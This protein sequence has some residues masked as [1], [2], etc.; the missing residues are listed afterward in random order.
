MMRI[1]V[2]EWLKKYCSRK[3]HVPCSRQNGYSIFE[4]ALII[5]SICVLC[6][7]RTWGA[8]GDLPIIKSIEVRNIGSGH[9]D[10]SFVLTHLSA[11]KGSALDRFAVSRDVKVL[12]KTGRFSAV[13]ADIEPVEDGVKLSISVVNK[14]KL[15]ERITIS[16]AEHIREGK[17]RDVIG[18]HVGDLV[19]M[20]VLNVSGQEVIREYKEDYYSDIELDW[21]I[22]DTDKAHGFA[23]VSLKIRE[24]KRAKVKE[25][26]FRGNSS[27]STGDLRKIMKQRSIWDPRRLFRKRRY[28]EDDLEEGRLLIRNCYLERGHLDVRV[29]DAEVEVDSKDRLTVTY[30]IAEG[31][32]YK[33]GSTAIEGI[34]LFGED[35]LEKLVEV[36]EGDVAAAGRIAAM[37]Q[38]VRDY[39]GQRG[40][41]ETSVRPLLS[42]SEAEGTVDVRFIVIEGALT[43]IRNVFIKGN[44]RTRDKVIR[45]ELLVY[46][47]EQYDEVK[48]RRSERRLNNLGFFSSV[49]KYPVDTPVEGQKDLMI[50]V[51]E[52]PTGTFMMGAGFSSVDKI[53]GFA[54]LSQ[55][56]FDLTGWPY[57]TGGGQKLKLRTQFGSEKKL[58]E[59]SFVE[60]WFMN[61]K[62]S[63]GLDIYRSEV[64][65]A[66]Y[67]IDRTGAAISLGRPLPGPNRM[68]VTYRIEK[69]SGIT[70]TNE[71]VYIDSDEIVTFYEEPM[72]KSSVK[73][74]ITHDTRNNPFIPTRGSKGNLF[75]S[76]SGGALG[77][78]AETYGLG[79]KGM[80]YIPLWRGH[81]LSVKGR[82][83]VVD[84]Y[85]ESDEISYSDRL[86]L[87][88]GRTLRG[89][90]YRDVGPKVVPVDGSGLYR[91]YG[92]RSLAQASASYNI[93]LV[94]GIRF[95]GF[96]DIGNVWKEAYEFDGNDL[97]SS[98]GMGIR[99]DVPGFP[100]RIDR[101]Y[102]LEKDDEITNTDKW[103]IWI[104][105]DY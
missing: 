44:I 76:V 39:Y 6:I 51:V 5:V 1:R 59:M 75:G 19:D 55:G 37:T 104:G 30:E 91:P 69:V 47:G 96:Y 74:Q 8:P 12:L 28:S 65:S 15:A 14:K 77:G 101:A 49:L 7:G 18:L 97:A 10:E 92:G 40:Y 4:T 73:L 42:P 48:I 23:K 35:N 64:S 58:Y 52:K 46:P 25:V 62:L 102:V 60:P 87:G 17:I 85:G 67:D 29:R 94:P 103:V 9:V 90:D 26:T 93:P 79:V 84:A 20:Q 57:F 38:R 100:V 33:F 54:E 45:R 88:G 11:A 70:D 21:T 34:T 56:N 95:A 24:G 105:H 89:F 36:R 86:F 68:D 2:V 22:E 78:D 98:V 41:I 61:R 53:T 16:G 81:Y 72:L 3:G 63:L 32:G 82:Y 83:E 50:E 27:V 99:M 43:K 13:S 31:M 66:D 80:H 71:Y